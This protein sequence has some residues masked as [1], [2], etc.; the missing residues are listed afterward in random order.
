MMNKEIDYVSPKE[1]L[2]M[3][4]EDY[5]A[6][7]GDSASSLHLLTA[8]FNRLE[9]SGQELC[10]KCLGGRKV[11]DPEKTIVVWDLVRIP[12]EELR[13]IGLGFKSL[14]YLSY[15]LDKNDLRLGMTDREVIKYIEDYDI[16]NAMLRTVLEKLCNQCIKE[17]KTDIMR[18]FDKNKAI[19]PGF[20]CC[21]MVTKN[22]FGKKQ[23]SH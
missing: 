16:N 13:H 6:K 18:T 14:G 17:D 2:K 5:V 4:V 21:V 8:I 9:N 1:I 11:S 10:S 15:L 7:Y 22:L 3:T 12:Q 19:R 20:I 23:S